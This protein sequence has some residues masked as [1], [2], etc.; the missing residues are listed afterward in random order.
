MDW[1]LNALLTPHHVRPPESFRQD[2][3]NFEE[4]FNEPTIHTAQIATKELDLPQSGSEDE[5]ATW[6]AEFTGSQNKAESRAAEARDTKETTFQ[7]NPKIL[8]VA[9]PGL[10]RIDEPITMPRRD[11]SERDLPGPPS[12]DDD[13]DSS[14]LIKD[15]D[16]TDHIPCSNRD[17]TTSGHY[18]YDATLT[19]EGL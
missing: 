9:D 5:D 3:L 8:S 1:N 18:D 13:E 10:P 19:H 15:L 4:V 7:R 12:R 17:M 16:L 2:P 6:L 14:P 11:G